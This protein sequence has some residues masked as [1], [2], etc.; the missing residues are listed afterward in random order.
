MATTSS[1]AKFTYYSV[2]HAAV[3]SCAISAQRPVIDVTYLGSY[4]T[5]SAP[6]LL[7]T[8]LTLD[9]FID[10]TSHKVLVTNLVDAEIPRAFTVLFVTGASISGTAYVTGFDSQ[11]VTGDVARASFTLVC[12]GVTS[13][14]ESSTANV[15]IKGGSE[16]I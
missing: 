11:I 15:S 2:D 7:S 6:G 1:V 9:V 4:N 8:A 5:Y 3:G 10:M 14:T 12:D 13:W 16:P